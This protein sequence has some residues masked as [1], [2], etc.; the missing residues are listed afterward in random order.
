MYWLNATT[1]ASG[2]PGGG[3]PNAGGGPG[4]PGG[5]MRMPAGDRASYTATLEVLPQ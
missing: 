2:R 5:P 1:G 3:A 4:G